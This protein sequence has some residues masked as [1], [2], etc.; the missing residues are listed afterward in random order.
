MRKSE[1]K[2][3]FVGGEI[4]LLTRGGLISVRWCVYLIVSIYA[5]QHLL[6]FLPLP[7]GQGSFRPVLTCAFAASGGLSSRSTSEISSGLSGS[8]PTMTFHP[9]L[10]HIDKISS[11]RFLWLH[12]SHCW[13]FLTSQFIHYYFPSLDLTIIILNRFVPSIYG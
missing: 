9:F 10:L 3:I 12:A 4:Y 2:T 5:P 8:M 1:R 6:Y 13:P 11:A 7:Q